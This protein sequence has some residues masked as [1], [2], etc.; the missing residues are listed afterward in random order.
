MAHRLLSAGAFVVI[1]CS[2]G[3]NSE[4]YRVAAVSGQVKL[5]GKPIENVAVMFQPVHSDGN[6]SPGPGSTGVTDADG[7]YTLKLTGKNTSG[8][9][10]G[11]HKV[12]FTM[13]KGEKAVKTTVRVPDKYND[14]E[15]KIEFEVPSAGTSAADFLLTS[16]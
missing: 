10:V 3:C 12:R 16:P 13:I 15:G 1:L 4:S 2:I 9:V 6:Y 14:R 8:A 11:K 5:D 7:R